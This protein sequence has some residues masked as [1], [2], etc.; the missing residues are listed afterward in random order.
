[1]A[2]DIVVDLTG[3]SIRREASPVID[4]PTRFHGQLRA[5]E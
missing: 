2:A 4:S 5:V 1:M 3:S